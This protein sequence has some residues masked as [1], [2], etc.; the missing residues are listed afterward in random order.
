MTSSPPTPAST[1]PSNSPSA[2]LARLSPPLVPCEDDSILFSAPDAQALLTGIS[3]VGCI[4]SSGC[5]DLTVASGDG[6]KRGV[7]GKL[8][9][10]TVR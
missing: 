5:A 9:V 8:S 1:S 7:R 3:S 2:P 4:N 10:F 6:I